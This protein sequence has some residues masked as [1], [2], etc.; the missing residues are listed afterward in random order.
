MRTR[1]KTGSYSVGRAR[2]EAI[3]DV[4]SEKFREVG[5]Y[6]TAM[7]R[8]ASDVG[9]SEG[10]LLHH[11]PSKKHLLLAVAQRRFE[12]TSRG[13]EELEAGV[14][15]SDPFAAMIASTERFVSEP[16]LIQLFVL[17]M[18]EAAEPASPAH[19]LFSDRYDRAVSSL[20]SLLQR[21]AEAGDIRADIDAVAIAQEC[22]AVSD[23]L[24]L[25][26]VISDGRI[27]IVER[28]RDFM[29]RLQKQLTPGTR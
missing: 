3:L 14:G 21:R 15:D 29:D 17:V 7:T 12:S 20:A 5:Y 10:G 4:A 19:A 11:F 18:S 23:G 28:I 24:Q 25:Q 13:W 6:R 16:G 27:D 1:A 2:R 26:W 22:I 9:L 8:I